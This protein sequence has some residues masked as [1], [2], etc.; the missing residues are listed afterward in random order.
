MLV[1][2]DDERSFRLESNGSMKV[3]IDETEGG[4]KAISCVCLCADPAPALTIHDVGNA[5]NLAGF[6]YLAANVSNAG[7]GEALVEI[8]PDADGWL[9]QGVV[10]KPGEAGTVKAAIP[11]DKL[12]EYYRRKIIGMYNLPGGVI[13][14]ERETSRIRKI[15]FV[16]PAAR[17]GATVLLS[18]IRA[19][20]PI[21]FPSEQE[22]DNGYFP[23]TDGFGQYIHAD[24][25]GKVHDV[26]ELISSADEERAYLES[27]LRPSGWNRFGGWEGGPRLGATGH[28]RVE[29]VD[30]KW[31]LVDPLGRLFWSHGIGSV[32]VDDGLVPVTDRE[33][34][35]SGLPDPDKYAQFYSD[36]GWA[37]P[38][39]YYKGRQVT[40]FDQTGWNAYRKYGD[41]WA[42]RAKDAVRER[43][44]SWGMNTIG[45]W[46]SLDICLKSRTPY[47]PVVMT[48]SR[49]IEG[50]AGHWYKFPDPYDPGFTANLK[51]KFESMAPALTDPY[52]IGF[53][54]D[55]ELTWGDPTAIGRWA[56][57]SPAGQPAKRELLRI[58]QQRHG[59]IGELNAV[60]G[61]A[62]PSW[63]SLLESTQAL[64]IRNR[65]TEDFTLLTV[66]E[67]FMRI[68]AV[69]R[70]LAPGKLYLGPR[71]DFHFYPGERG[72][73]DWDFRNDWIVELAAEY[74][75]V[76]SFNRYRHTAAD[77]RPGSRDRPV[78]IGEWH[79]VPLE[80]GSF[81]MGPE[82]FEQ[83]MRMRSEKYEYF[84]ESCLR[85]E[86]IVG[87]HYFQYM[88]QP[89]VGR[90]D[91]ENFCCG[92]LS[93]CDRPYPQ[94]ASASAHIGR[95]L[96]ETRYRDKRGG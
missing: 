31:W 82:H 92:F 8:R 67:Y 59:G 55:N 86:Y 24:W 44:L 30:G 93:I 49:R 15:S 37:A 78:I 42:E 29:K 91:G 27:H 64:D 75:D 88:D 17:A 50:S 19:E 22:L 23:L 85:N 38:F 84:A 32:N 20:S 70:E 45:A 94:T 63:E 33:F 66:R 71:L 43:L 41:G 60:W 65:D 68:K 14:S 90:T 46:S 26:D 11:Q 21:Q 69:L 12:P 81:F 34:Y 54:V 9:G 25:P 56:L 52:C 2:L 13:A 40:T 72:L 51:A 39:G 61:T 35:F 16:L 89:T 62:F 3:E 95:K 79:H 7:E 53:F 58:L 76:V 5:W 10:L 1:D 87:A 80:K 74:C 18:D 96:Y 36:R 4:G 83:S 6:R 48:D 73:N 77:L 28:F 47:T 57:A